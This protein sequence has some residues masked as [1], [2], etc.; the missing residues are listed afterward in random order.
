MGLHRVRSDRGAT[1][2]GDRMSGGRT[3]LL[4][5]FRRFSS[6]AVIGRVTILWTQLTD[7]TNSHLLFSTGDLPSPSVSARPAFASPFHAA[8]LN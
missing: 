7:Y 8:P 5:C 1:A 4:L 6:R 3:L 2:W